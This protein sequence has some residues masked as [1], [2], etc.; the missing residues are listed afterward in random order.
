MVLFYAAVAAIRYSISVSNTG[1]LFSITHFF[2][3]LQETCYQQAT[4]DFK[5]YYDNS[6]KHLF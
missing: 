3:K 4:F 5:R 1:I 6:K 2:R